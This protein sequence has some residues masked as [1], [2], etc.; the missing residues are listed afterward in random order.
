MI[1]IKELQTFEYL[2]KSTQADIKKLLSTFV[3]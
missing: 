3:G 2:A 1:S